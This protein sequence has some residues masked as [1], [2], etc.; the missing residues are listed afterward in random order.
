MELSIFLS[1]ID[2]ILNLEE[3]LRIIEKPNN[4]ELLKILDTNLRANQDSLILLKDQMYKKNGAYYLDEIERIYY[5]N[6]TCE[7]LIPSADNVKKALEFCRK[8]EY[9]FTLVTPYTTYKGID[10]LKPLFEYLNGLEDIE[11]VVNDFGVLHLLNNNYPNLIP[12]LGRLLNKLKRDP[13]FSVSG[14]EIKNINIQNIKKVHKNQ[15]EALQTSSLE[16]T[17]Y[18][19]MLKS[20]GISRVGMD[21]I[22]QGYNNKVCKKW[23]FPIDLYWPWAYITSSRSCAVAAYT[24]PSKS[25]HPTDENCHRQCKLLEMSF[26]SDK[27]MFK[28]VQRGNAIW[29]NS[30]KL[31][32]EYLKIDIH[33]LI[34]QPYIPL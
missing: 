18:Q 17:L 27:K 3:T 14:Y 9:G 28:N 32:E 2:N 10:N 7:F 22:P 24:Q 1:N 23:G 12:V 8:N 4:P 25:F 29:M 20:K 30:V 11:V 34:Y 19:D 15:E 33:R 26:T 16:N 21:S 13:R 5:G 31:L 6:E